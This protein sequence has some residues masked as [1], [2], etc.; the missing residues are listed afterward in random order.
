MTED[1]FN[2]IRKRDGRIVPFNTQKITQAIFKAAQAVGGEDYSLAEDV[3]KDVI[4]YLKTQGLPGLI[5]AVE[6]I[7][8][9]VE[10]ILIERGHARTAKA[11]ILYRDKRTRIREAKSELMDVVKDILLE[12]NRSEEPGGKYS[13][14]RKMHKI[15]LSASQKY[16]IDNLLPPE[17]SN[18]HQRGSFH[19]H[20]LGYYS[21]ALDSLHVDLFPFFKHSPFSISG[22]S[23]QPVHFFTTL[24]L[25][26]AII[27]ENQSDIY[28]EQSF[29]LFDSF[30]GE[31]LRKLKF[32]RERNR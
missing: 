6:E 14:A 2:E 26:F 8:D 3:T 21:K 31:L 23:E 5:P 30:L 28:G 4:E 27:Q 1:A 10:K 20:E 13:P 18:A 16:Y 17:I 9:A 29:P 25:F 11:Y 15:A 32:S 19:I 22:E 24:L 12:G 7:Q